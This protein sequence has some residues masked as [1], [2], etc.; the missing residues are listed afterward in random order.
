MLAFAACGVTR[1]CCLRSPALNL[2]FLSMTKLLKLRWSTWSLRSTCFACSSLEELLGFC[3][4]S[5]VQCTPMVTL[6][7][8]SVANTTVPMKL[9]GGVLL[10][11]HFVRRWVFNIAGSR[12]PRL[13]GGV[14]SFCPLHNLIWMKWLGCGRFVKRFGQRHA[15]VNSSLSSCMCWPPVSAPRWETTGGHGVLCTH[16]QRGVSCAWWSLVFTILSLLCV[17]LSVVRVSLAT[18]CGP[19]YLRSWRSPS[20]VL[21]LSGRA[22]QGFR[23]EPKRRGSTVAWPCSEFH[24][25]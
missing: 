14:F 18:Q 21:C 19:V 9:V 17:S 20:S 5:P 1:P 7:N 6:T 12:V 2:L 13:F 25:V 22:Q 4:K 15:L 11:Q 10:I 16:S 24:C 23:Q 8:G 3:L